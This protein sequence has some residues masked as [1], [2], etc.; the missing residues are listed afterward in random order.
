MHN[1]WYD[2]ELGRFLS[3][4]PIGFRGGLNLYEYASN[5]PLNK[6]DPGGLD[7]FTLML[8]SNSNQA[9][10]QYLA[11]PFIQLETACL[12]TGA[13]ASQAG[14]LVLAGAS[15]AYYGYAGLVLIYES[16]TEI[17]LAIMLADLGASIP[18]GAL[19]GL[20]AGLFQAGAGGIALYNNA[21][22]LLGND[23][24]GWLG[25]G[26]AGLGA[27]GD[28]ISFFLG[29]EDPVDAIMALSAEVEGLWV[30]INIEPVDSQNFFTGDSDPY[31]SSSDSSEDSDS[32]D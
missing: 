32:G 18:P 27:A 30:D 25:L 3:R 29:I 12:N 16:L 22:K 8:D 2:P 24:S 6:V 20:A 9:F 19:S 11:Q 4:D 21:N 28:L 15:G 7:G 17:R 10:Q 26:G 13:Q 1:R 14:L 5:N 23:P 31:S